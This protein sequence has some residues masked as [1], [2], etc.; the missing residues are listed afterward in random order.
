[1]EDVTPER[2]LP[3]PGYEGLYEVSSRGN[4]WSKPRP[5][6]RGG[7]LKHI[8]DKR[9]VHWVTLTLRGKQDPI[10]VHRL[11]MLTF[12]GPLPEGME[13]RHLDDN[14]SNNC[15][16]ENLVYGTHF[17]NMQDMVRNGHHL[18]THCK[19]GHEWTPEN[20]RRGSNGERLCRICTRKYQREYQRDLRERRRR[21]EAA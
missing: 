20:T 17:E 8:V 6:T 13:V 9:G 1:M 2:W 18:T 3:V 12:V 14:R 4:V 19:N 15:W 21:G 11:V 10:P 5:R 7:L 16:P